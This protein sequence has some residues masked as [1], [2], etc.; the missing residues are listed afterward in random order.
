VADIILQHQE[1]MDGSG[2][3]R[4]LKGE[5]IM[6]EAR[7][8]HVA[9]FVDGRASHRPYR[10]SVGAD[11]ALRELEHGKDTLF[12]PAVVDACLRLF[13]EKDYAFGPE[14]AVQKR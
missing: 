12:D 11:L 8:L 5:Q 14:L 4:G 10:T 7:I 13:R 3:P 6:T 9:D 1:N 2:Y